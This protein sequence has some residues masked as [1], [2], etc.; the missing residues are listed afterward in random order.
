MQTSQQFLVN[1]YGRDH[2]R[3]ILS[4]LNKADHFEC[5]VA[6]ATGVADG[7]TKQLKASLKRGMTG[8]MAVGLSGFV[9]E[10]K[11]L[12]SLFSLIGKND[13]KLYLASVD[14]VMFHPKIYGFRMGKQT[15]VL[16]GSANLTS[17]GFCDNYE[18]SAVIEN[19]VLRDSIR[20]PVYLMRCLQKCV[21]I[22]RTKVLKPMLCAGLIM[23][24]LRATLL[25]ESRDVRKEKTKHLRNFM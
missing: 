4:F 9:N 15:T 10:P 13:F 18:A 12:K 20:K 17:G 6:F 23:P 24:V 22:I 3:T 21:R 14:A 2:R 16:I 1:D 7:F 8:R 25:Q 19:S 5:L 11:C